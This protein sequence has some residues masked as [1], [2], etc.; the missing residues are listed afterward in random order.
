MLE[1]TVPP[2][3][4][5][6]PPVLPVLCALTL[7]FT[8]ACEREYWDPSTTVPIAKHERIRD[9]QLQRGVIHLHSVHSHD[10]CDHHPYVNGEPDWECY[11][12]LRGDLCDA[13]LQFVTVTEHADNYAW[14]D[15]PGVLLYNQE[16]GDRLVYD[17]QGNPYANIVHCQDGNRVIL[18]S[19]HQNGLMSLFLRRMPDGT[20]EDRYALFK[21]VSPEAVQAFRAL[22]AQVYIPYSDEWTTE[23]VLA[24]PVDGSELYNIRPNINPEN[25]IGMG[26]PPLDW[27][28]T[29]LDFLF[30]LSDPGHPDLAFL[31]FFGEN[32]PGLRHFTAAMGQR[33]TVGYVGN[34]VHRNTLPFSLWDGE[35]ADSY[36]RLMR[37]A[38]NYV[39]VKEMS[40]E[41][42][43]EAVGRGRM[44]GVFP[45]LGEPMG[46][47]F[48]AATGGAAAEMGDEI[49]LGSG[50]A[51]LHV[52]AP[53]LYG[54][55]KS[56][57]QPELK[58]RLIRAGVGGG[59]VVA[60]AI[61]TDIAFPVT[62]AAAY[63]AE[64]RIVPHHLAQWLGDDPAPMMRE[65]PFI[66]SNPIYVIP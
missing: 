4:R 16:A 11:W 34:D 39:L 60:E 15:F 26:L 12:D 21:T 35:R 8:A 24:M 1:R 36:R 14:F 49:S 46:F 56:F 31:T 37:W 25:R 6:T 2:H 40:V 28:L 33:R 5:R 62:E 63:R 29:V 47:D 64:V 22:G 66:Y 41:A 30:P 58:L 17:A 7:V 55:D 27:V 20:P 43:E 9:Y 44:F 50:E 48:H 3:P 51:V 54:I 19:G 52:K 45:V 59:V 61:N 57:P 53:R 10:A 38:M 65:Y 23:D 42:L 13:N 32:T 18:V